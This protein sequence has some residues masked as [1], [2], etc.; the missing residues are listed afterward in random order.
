MT[1]AE[2]VAVSWSGGKDAAVALW[3]LLADDAYEVVELLTTVSEATGRTTMHG[4]REDVLAAQAAALDVPLRTVELPEP[5]PNEEYARRMADAIE[6]YERRGVERMAFA[7][8][9]LEDVRAY[10]EERLADA[11]VDGL[12]PVWGRDTADVARAFAAR[13]EALVVCVDGGAL[14]ASF[15]GRAFDAAFLADIPDD[16]DPCGE[17]GEFHTFVSDG[18]PFD[19]PVPVEPGE[20]VTR[21]V[22]DGVAHYCEVTLAEGC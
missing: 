2:R 16:V 6:T 10:R 9:F 4:V 13:F 12:W 1:D 3:E 14:D 7:D 18:P 8:L 22:G 15:V 11:G 21:E 19:A 5:C 20:R 17:N